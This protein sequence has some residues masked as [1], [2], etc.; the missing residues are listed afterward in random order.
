MYGKRRSPD[1]RPCVH[2]R[3]SKMGT[4]RRARRTYMHAWEK[5]RKGKKKKKDRRKP[6]RL[7]LFFFFFSFHPPIPCLPQFRK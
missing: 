7:L 4:N 2:A 5:K 6:T 1:R 3:P